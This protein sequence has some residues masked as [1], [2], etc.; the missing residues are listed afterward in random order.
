VIK[1]LAD[2][3]VDP[4]DGSASTLADAVEKEEPIYRKVVGDAG[5]SAD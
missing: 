1:R 5:I 2:L 4:L 3:G